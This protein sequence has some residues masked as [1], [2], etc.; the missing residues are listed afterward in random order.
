MTK[1]QLD[2]YSPASVSAFACAEP[3]VTSDDTRDFKMSREFEWLLIGGG[4][5][6]GEIRYTFI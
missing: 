3:K 4:R 6:T 2:C 1:R 5:M